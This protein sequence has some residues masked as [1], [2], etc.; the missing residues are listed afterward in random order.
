MMRGGMW[1]Q[2]PDFTLVDGWIQQALELAREGSLAKAKAFTALAMINDDESAARSALAIAERLGNLDLRCTS[3][4]TLSGIA[5]GAKDFDPPKVR[6]ALAWHELG[7][8]AG[9][10]AHDLDW[11]WEPASTFLDAVAALGDRE[12]IEAE[13][14]KWL[15]HGTFDEPFALR[16]LG[17][18]RHDP[19][20]LRQALA[21]FQEMGLSWHAEQTRHLL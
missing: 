13:A 14:P 3:L 4:G 20:L 8:V 7:A 16:A 17:I 18:V 19:A 10:A 1:V 21:R 2:E 6:L 12:R 11:E 15:Q 9:L 5:L